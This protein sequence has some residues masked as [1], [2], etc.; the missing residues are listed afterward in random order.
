[1][2][3]VLAVLSQQQQLVHAAAAQAPAPS[4]KTMY[5]PGRQPLL[6][7][8]V[9]EPKRCVGKAC[10]SRTDFWG[11]TCAF[12]GE[13]GWGVC[14]PQQAA[15]ALKIGMTLGGGAAATLTPC[16]LLPYLRGRTLWILG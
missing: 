11:K 15:N 7:G 16:D 3:L 4:C 6:F 13:S 10:Q 12:T 1:M 9:A 2:L 14:T 8:G 5:R